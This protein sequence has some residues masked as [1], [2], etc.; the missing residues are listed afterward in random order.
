MDRAAHW[1]TSKCGFC[2]ICVQVASYYPPCDIG[3]RSS[4]YR[5]DNLRWSSHLW[6]IHNPFHCFMAKCQPMACAVCFFLLSMPF[7]IGKTGT[8]LSI[9]STINP[10]IHC[11]MA[12]CWPIRGDTLFHMWITSTNSICRMNR[13]LEPR[14]TSS[15]SLSF[16]TLCILNT[17]YASHLRVKRW[18]YSL[19]PQGE[20][21]HW[22]C[23]RQ[24]LPY[25]DHGSQCSLLWRHR[26][27][28]FCWRTCQLL[29]VNTVVLRLKAKPQD[30]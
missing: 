6:S 26:C 20:R 23:W 10:S 15:S 16:F 13:L 7:D 25:L 18:R 21:G 9:T 24:S 14:T 8:Y 29:W 4:I 2:A 5:R 28:R 12:K 30:N 27:P 1:K 17:M 22:W 19:H 11:L 3:K